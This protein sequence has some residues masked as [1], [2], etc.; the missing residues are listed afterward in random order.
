[1]WRRPVGWFIYTY[2]E[3][4]RGP[5]RQEYK[6]PYTQPTSN[7][8]VPALPCSTL[9][10]LYTPTGQLC[11][12]L[13]P[14]TVPEG[15]PGGYLET[16]QRTGYNLGA[17]MECQ[18]YCPQ[19]SAIQGRILDFRKRGSKL[20]PFQAPV[21]SQASFG[22]FYT[23]LNEPPIGRNSKYIPISC[24]VYVIALY[25]ISLLV[26]NFAHPYI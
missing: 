3:N 12:D 4:N 20:N 8:V 18:V 5:G 26:C 25:V 16:L 17:C 19:F 9:Y 11:I 7:Q 1:M 23:C 2:R 24:F 14:D 15:V 6:N 22:V 21:I 13:S 10:W